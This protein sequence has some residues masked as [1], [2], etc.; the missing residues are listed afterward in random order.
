[1]PESL[2]D[3]RTILSRIKD[4]TKVAS[5][6]IVPVP[7]SQFAEVGEELARAARKGAEIPPEIAEKMRRNRAKADAACTRN[8]E[9]K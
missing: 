4:K 5:K 7:P 3:G 1:L 8:S 2:R 9:N 6:K